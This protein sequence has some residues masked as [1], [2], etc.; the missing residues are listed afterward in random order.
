MDSSFA[1]SAIPAN[2]ITASGVA[3]TQTSIFKFGGGAGLFSNSGQNNTAYV[4]APV[5]V[6]GPL[7]LHIGD[8]T[9]EAWVYPTGGP[10]TAGLGT[11]FDLTNGRTS[12]YRVYMDTGYETNAQGFG[13]LS[14]FSNLHNNASTLTVGTWNHVALTR[15]GSSSH[16]YVNGVLLGGANPSGYG[17]PTSWGTAGGVFAIGGSPLDVPVASSFPGYIDEVRVT[18]GQAIYTGNS[19]TVP[20]SAP[21]N[22]TSAIAYG[23]NNVQADKVYCWYNKDFSEI[24]WHYP[25]AIAT[26]NDRYIILN[27]LEQCWYYGA[28]NRSAG[29]SGGTAYKVP[30]ATDSSGTLYLHETGTDDNGAAMGDYIESFDVQIGTGKQAM[31][32]RNFVPDM[33]RIAQ[34][35]QLTLKAKNRPQ[36]SS[37]VVFG[38]YSFSGSSTITGVRAAG[39]QMAIR[40]A[41]VGLGSDWRTGDHTFEIQPDGER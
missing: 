19:F 1:D 15:F 8:F 38:P 10:F 14:G 16:L 40:L 36:Q 29:S 13:P 21:A 7:D 37:Y 26:E 22:P 33:K 9:I 20:T 11:I 31:H 39:R 27:I 41:S 18:K 34:T 2:T 4:T 23:I 28:I 6:N 12:G 35:M 3:T 25:S 5:A 32:V 17:L 30:F 24:W